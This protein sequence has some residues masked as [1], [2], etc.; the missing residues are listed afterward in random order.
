MEDLAA[1]GIRGKTQPREI[2]DYFVSKGMEAVLFDAAKVCGINHMLSAGF[3]AKR[4]FAEGANRSR[5]LAMETILY[6]AGERQ[7][8]VAKALMDPVPGKP[9]GLLLFDPKEYDL[10]EIG[11]ERDDSA[12]EASDA[13]I[14]ALGHSN[15]LGTDP[16]K[17]AMEIVAM[18][19]LEKR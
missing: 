9:M 17:I 7:I 12:I 3:H 11:M 4:A 16:E 14:E 19:D 13:K 1:F 15:P 6:M 5:T 10:S 8:H 2:V 18:L